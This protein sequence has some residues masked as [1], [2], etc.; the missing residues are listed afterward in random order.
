MKRPEHMYVLEEEKNARV[1]NRW[2]PK[3][4]TEEW[5]KE[6]EFYGFFGFDNIRIK[7]IITKQ[8]TLSIIYL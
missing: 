2:M 5:I 8:T 7:R 6:K 4:A 3:F 1:V